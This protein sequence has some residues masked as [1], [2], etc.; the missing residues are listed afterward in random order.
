MDTVSRQ[1][2]SLIMAK[3]LS[4]HNKSTELKLVEVLRRQNLIGWRRNVEL[5]GKP[6]FIFYK[7]RVAIFVDGCFWHGCAKHCRMPENNHDYWFKKIQRNKKRD[8]KVSIALR[9]KGWR[10]LR[11]WEHELTR[12]NEIPLLRKIVNALKVAER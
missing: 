6:D 9:K 5:L 4:R 1:N 10:V 8:K 12:E 7:S 3:I 11:L 2:R